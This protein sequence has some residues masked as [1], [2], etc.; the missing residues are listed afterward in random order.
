MPPRNDPPFTVQVPPAG[1]DRPSWVKVGVIAAVGFAIGIVWP[2]VA[3]VR[4][5]P[6]APGDS[7][8]TA[9]AAPHVVDAPTN[10]PVS[11]A[12][13]AGSAEASATAVASAPAL[14][15]G[16]PTIFVG[17]GA[18][19]SCKTDDGESLKGASACGAIAPFDSFAQARF[20]RLAACSAA[21]GVTGRL[22]AT[23]SLDY[24]RNT[25]AVDIIKSSTVSNVE[26]IGVCLKQQFLGVNLLSTIDHTHPRYSIFYSA[27]FSIKEPTLG[28][29]QASAK[30]TVPL[31]AATATP[32]DAPSA[33]VVWEGRTTDTVHPIILF[34][35]TAP[36]SR[37]G[38]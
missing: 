35:R 24:T 13:A 1:E 11:I 25:I 31:A 33:S 6:T 30:A 3:G 32:M 4:L 8:P 18:V 38:R 36:H 7:A 21:D 26:S 23:L 16:P 14:P 37:H 9:S 29:A 34:V 2:R 27:N 20:R 28:A 5:G 17:R 22:A 19:V 10:V 12:S 15:S